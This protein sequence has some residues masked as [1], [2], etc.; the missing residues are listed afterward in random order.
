M[1]ILVKPGLDLD[2]T[3][4]LVGALMEMSRVESAV[5]AFVEMKGLA[6]TA[7]FISTSNDGQVI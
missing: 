1:S 6:L 5:A 7:K 3:V 2:V 4:W